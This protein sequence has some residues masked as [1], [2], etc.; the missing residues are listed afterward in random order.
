M[1]RVIR[2]KRNRVEW[3]ELDQEIVALDPDA[4]MYLSANRSGAVLWKALARG[5]KRDELVR[6]L[7]NAYGIDADTA[8]RD[9]ERFLGQLSDRGLLQDDE[10]V[11]EP[12]NP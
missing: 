1:E 8:Q 3:R 4:H 6:I 9:A 12:G 11:D 2:L 7:Q 5:A 10:N